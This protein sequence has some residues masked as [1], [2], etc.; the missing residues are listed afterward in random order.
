MIVCLFYLQ[1]STNM[2]LS[3]CYL[4]QLS[5]FKPWCYSYIYMFNVGT[6]ACQQLIKQRLLV[7]LYCDH[8]LLSLAL[9]FSPI[10]L[11]NVEDT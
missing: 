6:W 5:E 2:L 4:L 1:S 11:E 8:Y 9:I 10:T 7:V 3:E